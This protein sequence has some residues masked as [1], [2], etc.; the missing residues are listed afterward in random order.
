MPLNVV[1]TCTDRKTR[2]IR[3]SHMMR[4]V[5]ARHIKSRVAEWIRRLEASG[6]QVVPAADLYAGDHWAIVRSLADVLRDQDSDARLWVLSAGYGLIPLEG[7]VVPYS[8]TFSPRHPDSV[9]G[10]GVREGPTAL[11]RQ[12]WAALSLW[13][14]GG[15]RGPRS[16][17]ELVRRDPKGTLLIEASPTYLRAVSEDLSAA[18]TLLRAPEKLALFSSGSATLG[19]LARHR[20]PTST[21]LH[22]LLGGGCHSLNARLLLRAVSE[23]KSDRMLTTHVLRDWAKELTMSQPPVQKPERTPMSDDAVRTFI[24]SR[25]QANPK[26][27]HTAL[28]RDLRQSGRACE[29]KRF[30][31]LFGETLEGRS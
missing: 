9:S 1:V 24:A 8:A 18:A 22:S 14:P 5:R 11:A 2:P 4:S 23:A 6:E 16:L 12:W 10:A 21:R 20:V 25:L 29:Q 30:R 26:A 15:A 13:R 28:L 3:T 19:D 17:R 27:K 7:P 31:R